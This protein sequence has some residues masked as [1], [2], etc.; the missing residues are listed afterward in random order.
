MQACVQLFTVCFLPALAGILITRPMWRIRR[1]PNEAIQGI[2][3]IIL[4]GMLIA[5][6]IP[7]FIRDCTAVGGASIVLSL[8]NLV[9]FQY[10]ERW[11][12]TSRCPRC[13]TRSLRIRKCGKGLYKLY[14]PHC[15]LHNRWHSWR[16]SPEEQ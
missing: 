13:H 4:I 1:L 10:Y 12:N 15:G 11:L 7:V 16:Y 8:F 9:L 2:A 6:L 14:C 3:L 5:S